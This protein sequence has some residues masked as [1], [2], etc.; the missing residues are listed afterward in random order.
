MEFTFEPDKPCFC[1]SNK[2]FDACCGSTA[3]DRAP[4]HGVHVVENFLLPSTCIELV[5]YGESCPRR[6]LR[7]ATMKKTGK[8]VVT[9][10]AFSKG[11]VTEMVEYGP[12][13]NDIVQAMV[14]AYRTVIEPRLG[15]RMAW[16]ESPQ[17][18]RYEPG[19]YYERHS[20]SGE[21]DPATERWKKVLDRDVSALIY[22]NENYSGGELRF[23]NFNYDL[24][25]RTGMLLFFP[26]DPRYLHE[27]LPLTSG[28]K[29]T[30]AGWAAVTGS[31]KIF[32][33]APKGAVSL[34]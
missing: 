18:L 15:A 29:Y 14:N 17:V 21:F 1:G 26:S 20:D 33:T 4:P 13:R 12:R 3:P 25:P 34:R 2:R 22:L 11:R 7:V 23:N 28:F 24:K 6:R 30:I 19:G 31:K 9:R 32:P 5:N 16:V 10:H 27:S 8:R